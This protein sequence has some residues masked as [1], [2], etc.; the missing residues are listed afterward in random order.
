MAEMR[1]NIPLRA[2]NLEDATFVWDTSY[3]NILMRDDL[4]TYVQTD[5][6]VTITDGAVRSFVKTT[7]DFLYPFTIEFHTIIDGM[8]YGEVK[9]WME[10]SQTAWTYR[11]IYVIA[12][13]IGITESGTETEFGTYTTDESS[14]YL[15]QLALSPA[16]QA[17]T[18][19]PLF[20]EIDNKILNETQKL[21]Y[22][23]E[24]YV[25]AHSYSGSVEL[26]MQIEKNIDETFIKLP[27]V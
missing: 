16:N 17:T 8:A 18:A 15:D 21:I 26:Q 6:D 20:I 13:I 14:I 25:K 3:S 1:F 11:Y 5:N 10:N 19:F 22:R 4:G 24:T 23:I 27:I 7:V 9:F 2:Q 12:K